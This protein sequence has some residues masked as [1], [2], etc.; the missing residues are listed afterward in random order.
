M[1]RLSLGLSLTLFLAACSAKA[2]ASAETK[3]DA[4]APKPVVASAPVP[5]GGPL[6]SVPGPDPREAALSKTVLE[7]LEQGHLLHKKIDDTVSREAFATYMDRVDAGKMFLLKADRDALAKYADKID[8]EL[9]SGSLDLGHDGNKIF[10]TRVAVVDKMVAELLAK[11]FDL[12][13]EESFETDSDKLKPAESESELKERWRQR[14]E[15][16]VLERTAAMEERLNPPKPKPSKDKDKKEEPIPPDPTLAQIPPTAEGREAKARADLA[17]TY[18]ARFARLEKPVAL[19]AATDVINA[20]A[21]TLDP[22]TLYLPPAD[23]AN[24][25]IQMSGSLEGIGASLRERDHNIE[26]IELI[27][28]GAAARQGGL[29]PGDIIL[30]VASGGKDPVDVFDMRIDDVVKMIRGPKNSVVT[31]RVRKPAGTDEVVSIT[32]DVIVIEEAYARGAV[33]TRKGL[34]AFGYIHL[35]SFY[36]GS[37]S[38][39][40]TSSEDVHKLLSELA[41]KKVR[42]VILD[43]RSNGGGILRDAIDLTGHLIDHGPVVQVQDSRGRKEVLSDDDRGLAFDGQVIVL[44]DHFSASA[45]EIVAGALQD[46]RRALIVGTGPTHGK[47]TVQTL[48]DLDSVGGTQLDLGVL[49]LT[50]QQFFRV[51]GSSTQREGVVPDIVLPDPAGHIDAGEQSLPHALP[52]SKISSAPHDDWKGTWNTPALVL[53]SAGRVAKHPLLSKVATATAFL[54]SRK[55][56]TIIPLSRKA[57][58]KRRK[59]LRTALDAA[60]PDL[61]KAGPAFAVAGLDEAPGAK[62]DARTTRW[63][64]N[65]AKD[66]WVDE[67]LN[68]LNDMPK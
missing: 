45:S 24:F 51:S 44:V 55:N 19:D 16:E 57:W 26:I 14:L 50:I 67:C 5:K 25:E 40:R 7:L 34:P 28:G 9:N 13:N 32:R 23:K 31:L 41:A 8:D 46:Y 38:G 2:P 62:P 15:L 18:A 63:R 3:H 56:D 21:N 68:I 11:P 47:G 30:T 42:G 39:Q 27:P 37:G 60:S 52:W 58:D 49:K 22:H 54:R 33:L 1:R 43:L 12:D 64:E 36:G 10:T 48:A 17:K 65:L 20:V 6:A 53:K 35:P 29:G 4:V 66:P 61:D 59:D